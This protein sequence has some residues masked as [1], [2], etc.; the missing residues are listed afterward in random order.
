MILEFQT[1]EQA[2][3][4]LDILDA[5]VADGRTE[6]WDTVKESPDGTYYF[7]SFK[8]D[9]RFTGADVLKDHVFTEKEFPQEWILND[10]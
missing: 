5:I 9:P 10:V 2:Q 1:Q 3:S 6:R 7:Y 4:A 8:G